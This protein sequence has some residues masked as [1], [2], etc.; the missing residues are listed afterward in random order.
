MK[1]GFILK[2][3]NGGES[4]AYSINKNDSWARY[5]FDARSAIKELTNY[6]GTGKTAYLVKLMGSLGYLIC[7]IKARPEGSGRVNDNT[8]AWIYIPANVV[9][10][11]DETI[12][13]LQSVEEAISEN[14]GTD[15]DRLESLF[16][17]EHEI[18]DVLISAVGTIYSND[19]S[20][21]AI[22]YYNGDYTL[23][24]LVGRNIAQQEYGKY[25][26]ILLVDKKQDI[27]FSSIQEL[28]FE[29][30]HICVYDP[31]R[32][33][34]GFTPSFHSQNKYW[35]FNKSIE[36]PLGTVVYIYWVKDGY[37]TIK[38]TFSAQEGSEYPESIRI[39]PKEYKIIIPKNRFYVIDPD[40]VPVNQFDVWINYHLMEGDSMEV[41]EAN[42]QQGLAVSIEA[43]GF[44]KW[45]GYVVRPQLDSQLKVTLSKKIF[46]YEFAIPLYDEEKKKNEAIV[47]VETYQ[48]LNSSPIKG[49]SL[50]GIRIQEGEGRVNRLSLDDKLFSKLKYMAYG[51]ASCI[52][53][54]LMYAACSTLNNY[55]F[56]NSWP[57]IKEKK[58]VQS[59]RWK[60][61]DVNSDDTQE[62]IDSINAIKYLEENLVWH[63]DSLENN[64]ITQGLFSE[65]NEFKVEE[66]LKR[67]EIG[68]VSLNAVID[69]LDFYINSEK[70]DPRKG[71]EDH[72]GNYNSSSDKGINVTN[73]MSWLEE[74]HAPVE[75]S[76]K[77]TEE[78]K[79][80]KSTIKPIRENKTITKTKPQDEQPKKGG[81]RGRIN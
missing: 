64:P 23:K 35:P 29:P 3:T 71:K 20:S 27:G 15:Y 70:K 57:F 22:R 73:Y 12:S 40:G 32:P 17:K 24:E 49:Y 80:V 78:H 2:I 60:S 69:K 14:K 18:H 25:K 51:F 6:D 5:A 30:R 79:E 62:N 34:D 10:S 75:I 1:L 45:Q 58:Q 50:E 28:N 42:Y 56:K 61:A 55:E 47:T 72:G 46:H 53:V 68:S 11:S 54:L 21:Y 9:I 36:V 26:G 65:L 37:K 39:D 43:K 74:E 16:S 52:F 48:E 76:P 13:I 38:K 33:I 59:N 7:V 31:L 44:A 81:P 77:K 8:A 67:K 41:L 19:N 66:L 63:K 4:E